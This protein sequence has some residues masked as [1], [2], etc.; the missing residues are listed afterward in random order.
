MTRVLAVVI[1]LLGVFQAGIGLWIPLGYHQFA[2][3]LE[4]AKATGDPTAETFD[5]AEL[6]SNAAATSAVLTILG[7]TFLISGCGLFGL[8]DW[9]RKLWLGAISFSLVFYGAWFVFDVQ[10]GHLEWD[11]WIELFIVIALFCVSWWHLSRRTTR[12]T[13]AVTRHG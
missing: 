12:K 6:R 5:M 9:A 3:L 2:Q 13:F 11:N 10:R 4:L 8:R 1:I 7:T